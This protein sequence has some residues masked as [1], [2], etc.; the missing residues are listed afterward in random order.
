MTI[1]KGGSNVIAQARGQG[2][3]GPASEARECGRKACEPVIFLCDLRGVQVRLTTSSSP[4]EA[5]RARGLDLCQGHSANR[6]S[7]TPE[8]CAT[9]TLDARTRKTCEFRIGR[10]LIPR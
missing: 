6:T 5:S 9:K 3:P 8:L 4:D 1:L 10:F 7:A 2:I